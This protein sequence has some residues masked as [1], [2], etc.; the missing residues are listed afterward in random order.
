[1]YRRGDRDEMASYT[2]L[3]QE[4]MFDFRVGTS[5][6]DVRNMSV[7]HFVSIAMSIHQK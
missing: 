6:S 1:M 5:H 2:H 4:C 3:L 7:G